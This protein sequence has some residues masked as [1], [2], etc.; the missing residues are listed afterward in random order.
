MLFSGLKF[1]MT[2]LDYTGKGL[3]NLNRAWKKIFLYSLH[4]HFQPHLEPV[5]PD[6][7]VPL[8]SSHTE[9]IHQFSC[10]LSHLLD[11]LQASYVC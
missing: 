8:H 5:T 11:T 6:A 9:N 3:Y 4:H 1:F 2:S 10:G 7:G